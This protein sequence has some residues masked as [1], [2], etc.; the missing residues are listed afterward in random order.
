MRLIADV[1]LHAD[2]PSWAGQLLCRGGIRVW[3]IKRG[4]EVFLRLA[5][6]QQH[7]LYQLLSLIGRGEMEVAVIIDAG[8]KILNTQN[9]YAI[10]NVDDSARD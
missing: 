8:S 5:V 4:P 1:Q 6:A 10:L 7:R 3:V 2:A 9:I